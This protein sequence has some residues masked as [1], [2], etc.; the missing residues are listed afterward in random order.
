[1]YE[2]S[3]KPLTSLSKRDKIGAMRIDLK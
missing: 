3:K 2:I 1:M